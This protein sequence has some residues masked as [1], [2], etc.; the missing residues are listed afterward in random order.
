MYTRS[1]RIYVQDTDVTGV[2][3]FANLM[4]IGIET[5]EEFLHQQEF[6]FQNI[7]K[8]KTLSLPIVHSD[9]DFESPIFLGDIL[10]IRLSIQEI[11]T[12]SFTHLSEMWTKRG[13]G[14]VVRFV[15]VAY[16]P[17]KEKKIP[18]PLELVKV[19]SSNDAECMKE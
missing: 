5:F 8:E 13:R 4:H 17:A 15:H 6:D 1:R 18:L 19:L 12:S 10:E 7:L 11:G 2:I 16:S 14:A 9:A 3:Y